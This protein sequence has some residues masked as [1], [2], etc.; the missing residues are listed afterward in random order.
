MPWRFAVIVA[1]IFLAAGFAQPL[2]AAE[3]QGSDPN[4][5]RVVQ[6]SALEAMAFARLLMPDAQAAAIRDFKITRP[7]AAV[8]QLR[9]IM[10]RDELHKSL[11]VTCRSQGPA[12]W[13]EKGEGQLPRGILV[14]NLFLITMAKD[15]W[16]ITF[17]ARPLWVATFSASEHEPSGLTLDALP[18]P[19]PY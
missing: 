12:E 8:R 13:C 19:P 14:Q 4:P 3:A 18:F 7:F 16:T 15:K 1:G 17:G 2:P 9:I 6:D 10:A 11:R 5:F